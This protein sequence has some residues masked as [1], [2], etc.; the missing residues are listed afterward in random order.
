MKRS[1]WRRQHEA[2]VVTV[3]KRTASENEKK[4]I[5]H[6]NVT[7]KRAFKATHEMR[8]DEQGWQTRVLPNYFIKTTKSGCVKLCLNWR[9]MLWK[10]EMR[11]KKRVQRGDRIMLQSRKKT[12]LT[13]CDWQLTI[14]ENICFSVLQQ[15]NRL[16]LRKWGWKQF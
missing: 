16:R 3:S 14:Q 11:K 2:V 9:H 13:F 5:N 1:D 15:Y 7:K 8:N 4:I 12:R 10:N 6:R